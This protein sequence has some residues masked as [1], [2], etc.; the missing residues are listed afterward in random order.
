MHGA[1]VKINVVVFGRFM[2]DY[3]Q[4][5]LGYK[6]LQFF[7]RILYKTHKRSVSVM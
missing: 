4:I 2:T 1:T 3:L 7:F 6:K 5:H